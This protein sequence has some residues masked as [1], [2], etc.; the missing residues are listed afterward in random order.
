MR[1]R[2]QVSNLSAFTKFV[3]SVAKL[4]KR[5]VFKFT[6]TELKVISTGDLDDG[7]RFFGTVHAE[8]IE[9]NQFGK[10][11]R[12][13]ENQILLELT[14]QALNSVLKASS[15]SRSEIVIRLGKNGKTPVLSFVT[16]AISLNRTEYEL[17]QHIA[18]RVVKP[19][20]TE[21]LREPQTPVPDI[22]I[23]LPKLA[24]V[25]KV[26]ERLKSLAPC[27]QV[28]ANRDGCLKLGI[29]SEHV[30]VETEWHGLILGPDRPEQ[31]ALSS[32]N[33]NTQFNQC[34]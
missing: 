20:D 6:P 29:K 31:R 11:I 24:D 30:D 18:V 4:S 26:A 22:Q 16:S 8:E 17:E 2:A 9:L 27:I 25:C 14:T 10:G 34:A 7:V 19:N 12:N 21:I 1:F 23:T 28:S 33:P 3:E 5:A 32:P 13:T 15:G